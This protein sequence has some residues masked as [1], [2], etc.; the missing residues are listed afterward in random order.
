[1]MTVP[2]KLYA[3]PASHPCAAVARALELKR[4]PYERIDLV[5]VLHK[6]VSRLRFGG[7]G[8]VPGVVL[9]DG[10]RV[11]GSRQ[12]MR[13]LDELVAEPP[14]LPPDGDR[15][16][17]VLR[18]EQ[19]GDE[20]LQPLVRRLLW[21]ALSERPDAQAS[22]VAGARLVPPSPAALV[23][24][25]AGVVA[26]LERRLHGSTIPAVRADLLHLPNHL[27]R[28]DRWLEQ[29][30]LDAGDTPSAADLQI[31]SSLRLALTLADL[32]PIV[33]SRPAGAFARRV[34]SEY[35][36]ATPAGALPAAW[37]RAG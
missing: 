16:A 6:L 12:I 35:P 37:L 19:W 9:A 28:I 18:A 10:R 31:A 22:Y 13:A 21:F 4:I 15:R 25:S 20:L 36:G 3:I 7:S 30:V 24:A 27:D 11:L 29:G 33:D 32:A 1:M 14:L 34:F 2:A 5:P 23:Q 8:T 17:E 26:K